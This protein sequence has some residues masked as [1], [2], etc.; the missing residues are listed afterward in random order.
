MKT[1]FFTGF[2]SY[3]VFCWALA[4]CKPFLP[5]SKK[6]S[7]GD[8]FLLILMK[9][10]LGL[11]NQDLS[12]RFHISESYVSKLL[13]SGLPAVAKTLSF[14]VRWPE[15]DEVLRTLPSVFK[16]TYK[17][18]RVIIDYTEIFCERARNLTLQALTWSNYKHHNTLK[19]LVGISPTGAVLFLSRAF[20]GRVSDKV[21][22]QKSVFLDLIEHGDQILADRGFLINE[23]LA[24]RG[25]TIAMPSFTR[26][27]NNSA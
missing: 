7:P 10:R 22:T 11:L 15:K 12:F 1:K 9:V 5:K 17:N 27:R 25:A 3:S 20:G 13:N 23:E 21:I 8:I 26:G 18:C 6:L 19:V 2:P 24:S 4:L 14:L 16:P